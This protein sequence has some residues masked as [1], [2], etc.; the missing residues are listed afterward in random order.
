METRLND[1]LQLE[2]HEIQ[3]FSDEINYYCIELKIPFP[4]SS[5]TTVVICLQ[6][7]KIEKESLKHVQT[8]QHYRRQYE[9]VCSNCECTIAE[10]LIAAAVSTTAL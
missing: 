9:H 5:L 2:A 6:G 3:G 10:V 4:F 7:W 1:Q 8:E